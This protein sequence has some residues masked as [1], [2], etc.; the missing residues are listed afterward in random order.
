MA[1][2]AAESCPANQTQP[3]AEV[4][5][6]TRML[7]T[8]LPEPKAGSSGATKAFW[9]S[10]AGTAQSPGKTRIASKHTG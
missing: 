8:D 5:H 7:A 9:K 2:I 10:V 3:Q 4:A 6:E 1:S